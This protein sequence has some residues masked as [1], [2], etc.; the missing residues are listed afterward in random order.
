[1]TERTR[2]VPPAMVTAA[3]NASQLPRLIASGE[4][5]EGV[6]NPK[7]LKHPEESGNPECTF[8]Q[9]VNYYGRDGTRVVGVHRYMRSDGSLGGSGEEDPKLLLMGDEVWISDP[10]AAQ[11]LEL[12][13][14]L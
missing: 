5:R 8:S 1:M 9:Y 6:H 3:F 12:P 4:L 14:D 2:R 13:R 10:R 7:H 11:Q